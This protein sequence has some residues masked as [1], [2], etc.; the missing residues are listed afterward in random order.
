MNYTEPRQTLV[1]DTECY[2]DYW[3]IGFREVENDRT[4]VLELYDG[5]ELDRMRI[6]KIIRNWRI[7]TFNGINYDMPMLALA[8]TG[9]TT[10]QL[11][12]LSDEIIVGGLRPWH[13]EERYGCRLPTYLDH[14]DL[15]EV[16]PGM[17]SLKIYGGR[18]HSRRMQDL[19]IEP[20]EEVGPHRRAMLRSYHANDLQTTVDLYNKLRPQVELRASMSAEYGMD[21]RSKS[22]AQVAEAVIRSQLEKRGVTVRRPDIRIGTFRY[23]VPPFIRYQTKQMLDLLDR[24]RFAN[25]NVPPSGVVEMPKWLSEVKI[26]L[27]TGVYRMGIGGLHS[28]ESSVTH[29]S[30]DE[31]TLID[32]DVRSYYPEIILNSRLAPK[33]LG[34]AFLEVYRRIVDRRLAAKSAGDKVTADSLKITVNGS[35]GKLGSPYSTL[36]SP[37]LMI[38]VTITGQLSLL[39]L[40]ERL[41]LAG[42]EVLSA[43]TDGLVTKVPR[44]RRAEFEA[45]LWDWE[46]DTCFVT[47]EVEYRALHSRDVNSYIAIGANGKVK[48]KGAYA[49]AGLQKN[50][51][52]EIAVR[53]AVAYLATGADIEATVRGCSDIRQF[54]AI[55]TVKGGAEK[56][57]WVLGKAIRW[58]YSTQ[59]PGPITYRLNGNSV[60]R[61]EGAMPCMELPDELPDD[62][63]YDWYV[64]EA[65]AILADVGMHS[66][67]PALAGRRG[68]ML[69]RKPDQKNLHIVSLPSGVALCGAKPASIRDRWVEYTEIPD[70]HRMCSKC[71]K[72]NEL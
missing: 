34:D 39:M 47:E 22:D 53:A 44:S 4:V 60:P 49:E 48:L 31:H 43:N 27:G 29:Y 54:V 26:E 25:F 69:A 50:P 5:V 28:S 16:A 8:M 2:R 17:A 71:R 40:I 67:D 21:L 36:Y 45:I 15:F 9:A 10:Q 55:R 57:G 70:G 33:H 11:K 41:T 65:Y 59:A 51:T 6:A 68:T 7:V 61:S 72:E 3:S 32:R 46:V 14:I 35:F 12:Q 30:D 13:V 64:R 58:Y 18:V 24:I 62:I 37:E 23:Q 56:H 38:Q 42:F 66:V 19:P 1:C 52:C 63:D 20:H